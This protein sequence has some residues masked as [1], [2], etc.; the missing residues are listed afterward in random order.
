[1]DNT[2]TTTT[3]T[4]HSNKLKSIEDITSLSEIDSLGV[5]DLKK[6]LVINCIDYKGCLERKELIEKV[7][8]LWTA[9]KKEGGMKISTFWKSFLFEYVTQ[10]QTF[11][12]ELLLFAR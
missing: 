6:I 10:I 8:R 7:K 5:K 2:P 4:Q 1:M 12:I 3:F 11:S 9:Q